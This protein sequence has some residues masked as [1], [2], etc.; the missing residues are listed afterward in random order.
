MGVIVFLGDSIT[1]ASHCFLENPLGNGYVNMVAEKLNDSDGGRKK[2]DIMNR[3]HDGFTIHGVKRILE[4]ECILKRPDVVSILIGCNDVGVM[5]NT[6]KSL[7]EQQF[8]ACYEAIVKEILNRLR[9]PE[10]PEKSIGVVSFSQVQQ[11]LIEDM[12]IEELNKYPE[13]E[14]KAFQ[15]NEP[16]FIKNLENVQ[17]DERDI[18]LFSI[19]YGPDRNGNVSMNFGPLNN[20]GGERRLNVAVSRARHEMIIFSTLRSEQIDLK[21]TKSKGVEGLKRFLEFAERGTSP[22]PA[23]QLQNLQQSNLITLIAQELTQRGYKVDTL[24]GRSNFK[25]DL[26]IVNPLQPDTYILGILCDGRNYYETK[27]TRDREIAQQNDLQMLHWNV[28]RV[29]SVDWFE[30][31]ENVVERSIK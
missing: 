10:V 15:S 9:T 21:R 22:V 31:K 26:A 8:E 24:V 5:M 17:G 19:G 14:E 1:D 25:V 20:Q 7:E 29:W 4:K 3:G 27:T 23:I 12:L 11:N 30:H 28:M 18:I 6:G 16:I 13:L 2:Y